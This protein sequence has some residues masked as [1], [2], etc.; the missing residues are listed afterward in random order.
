MSETMR[1]F[2]HL[3]DEIYRLYGRVDGVIYGAGIIEDNCLKISLLTP[4][5]AF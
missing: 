3:I 1:A 4:S 5:I 2:G